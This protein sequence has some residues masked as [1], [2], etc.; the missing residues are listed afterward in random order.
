MIIIYYYLN[1]HWTFQAKT[2][3]LKSLVRYITVCLIGFV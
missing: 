2:Q 1:Y 3:H